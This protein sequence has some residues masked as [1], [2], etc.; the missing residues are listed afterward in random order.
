MSLGMSFSLRPVLSQS[1]RLSQEQRIKLAQSAFSLRMRLVQV[2]RDEKYEPKGICPECL[3]KMT[4]VEII[5][6]F[7]RNSNDFTTCCSGCGYR[8]EPKLIC[9]GEASQIE[10]PF[11]CG[12]QALEKLRGRENFSPEDLARKLPGVYQSAIIHF[13]SIRRAFEKL[14][15]QYLFEE[16]S[17]WK[18]KVQPFLGRLRDTI[19]A[20]CVDVP[21]SAIRVMRRKQGIPRYTLRQSLEEADIE[22]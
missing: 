1:L 18:I 16:I 20:E 15:V 12:V 14:G 17:D 19:I 22:V 13:G 10:I 5:K 21:V 8:F 4:P 6:G 11:F 2:L 9:F 7:N 3:R